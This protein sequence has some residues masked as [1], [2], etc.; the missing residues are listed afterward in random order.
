MPSFVTD[1]D[2]YRPFAE[3]T[4]Q[5]RYALWRYLTHIVDWAPKNPVWAARLRAIDC[6]RLAPETL[7][8]L[9]A[10]L[11]YSKPAIAKL[12]PRQAAVLLTAR[13]IVPAQRITT[14]PARLKTYAEWGFLI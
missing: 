8:L 12:T 11:T 3:L 9:R 7:A 2:L 1:G 5:G 14:H 4:P 6:A 10:T 13:P